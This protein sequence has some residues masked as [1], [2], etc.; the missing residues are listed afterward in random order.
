MYTEILLQLGLPRNQAKIYET[1][2]VLGS[3]NISSISSSAKVN[4]RNVYDSIKCLL[5]RRLVICIS[6][7]GEQ[8]YAA[9]DPEELRGILASKTEVIKNILPELNNLY[10]SSKALNQA[11]IERGWEGMK[12]FWKFILAEN[13]P[14][15][16]IGGK[17]AWHD[18]RIE[19]ERVNFFAACK[20]Q[21]IRIQGIFDHEIYMT[22]KDIYKN[23]NPQWIRFFPKEYSTFAS[24]DICRDQVIHFSMPKERTIED[25]SIF[26]II[27]KDLADSYR[28]WFNYLWN[29]A[30]PLQKQ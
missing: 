2:L 11:S 29:Q 15:L 18:P 27:S 20:N 22:G 10:S 25:V 19:A 1:L 4:R 16:F 7:T 28:T 6:E 8:L 24:I 14:V 21:G 12:N 30:K 17:G 9:V 23:Y 13:E 3:S 5:K 26:R